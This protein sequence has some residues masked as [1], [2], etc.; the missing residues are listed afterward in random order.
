MPPIFSVDTNV[1]FHSTLSMKAYISRPFLDPSYYPFSPPPHLRKGVEKPFLL[2]TTDIYGEAKHR[3]LWSSTDRKPTNPPIPFASQVLSR[4]FI[5]W[6]IDKHSFSL[7]LSL[8]LSL[9]FSLSLSLSLSHSLSL[10][11]SPSLTLSLSLSFSLSQIACAQNNRLATI[12]LVSVDK[13]QEK[14]ERKKVNY[15]GDR[16]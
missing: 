6:S 7:F 3:P 15:S 12:H 10:S 4:V 8:S 14:R 16:K 9:S 11:V 1:K 2:S 13:I 5:L